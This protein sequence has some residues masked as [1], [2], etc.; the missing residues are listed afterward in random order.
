[1][2]KRSPG[3]PP[4]P[5]EI[6]PEAIE[7]ANVEAWKSRTMLEGG[8]FIGGL[9]RFPATLVET[10]RTQDGGEMLLRAGK[11][12]VAARVH[13]RDLM[14]LTRLRPESEL[15]V[16]GIV[17][18]GWS[19]DPSEPPDR[20]GLLV[21]SAG[22]VVLV[23][24][25]SWWT[26][27]RLLVALAAVGAVLA[28]AVAWAVV[29]RRQ[30]A[31]QVARLAGEIE[32]R[33]EAAIAFRAALAERNRLANN[34]HDTLL[35][36]LAGAVLQIDSSRFALQGGRPDAA[37][38][39]IEKSKRMVQRAANDLRN[40]VWA[41]RVAPLE[42]HSFS[43]SLTT[44]ADHLA[45]GDTPRIVVHADAPAF[46]LP[47]FVAGNLLL[48]AQEAIRN[49]VHHA[50]PKTVDVRV[51]SDSAT[52]EVTLTVRDDG[53][54]FDPAG[55]AGT[56]QGHFGL[57]VMQERME[58]MGGRLAIES[59]PGRGTTIIATIALDEG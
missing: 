11:K 30:V 51:E 19:R 29:L 45:V 31:L 49:A 52:R 34:L 43:E 4:A 10:R 24:P 59:L 53:C 13:D 7:Q 12:I 25:P 35:Q 50:D 26:P 33:R 22:D 32:K 23:R 57:L 47:E 27:R 44:M 6:M 36:G 39:Q 58:G 42:G 41:L 55:A 17:M 54:G 1:V 5:L 48:V 28:G 40:S 2:Q 8:D 56:A 46:D 20:I 14:R 15:D 21:R 16:T 37:E 18:A 38:G 9:V 3:L